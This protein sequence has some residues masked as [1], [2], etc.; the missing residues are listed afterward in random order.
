LASKN[1]FFAETG[2]GG[3]NPR[4]N[5]KALELWLA[6][7]KSE[8]DKQPLN[9]IKQMI[10]IAPNERVT[11]AGLM[12]Q[13]HNYEDSHVYYNSC[14]NGEEESE[15][16]TSYHGSTLEEDA[17][18]IKDS[19]NST[20]TRMDGGAA[21]TVAPTSNQDLNEVSIPHRA[22]PLGSLN[23]KN[24]IELEGI[25]QRSDAAS[26]RAITDAQATQLLLDNSFDIHAN[27]FNIKDALHWAAR[28]GHEAVVRLLVEKGADI[29]AKSDDRWTALNHAARGGHETVVRLL[30][31]K[32]ADID[33]KTMYGWTALNHAA[34]GGHEAV[35]RLLVEKGA[36]IN[37]KNMYGWA[38]LNHGAFG[39]HEA[40]VRLLVEKGADIDVMSDDGQTA[41][42]HAV[43]GGHEAV[44]RLLEEKGADINAKNKYGLTALDQAAFGGHETVVRLLVEKGADI[45]AKNKYGQTALDH[46][47]S[48][49][50]EAVVRLLVEKGA[51]K[52]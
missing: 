35:A 39:G 37:A 33:T 19:E 36:D 4:T 52:S 9:W 11:A 18:A 30:I 42:N 15:D 45:N 31:E 1:Q 43:S 27:I 16:G 23:G 7:L 2:T 12:E 44:V 3:A 34:F 14:C 8:T 6:R 50:H 40:V 25:F 5:T 26:E 10:K 47:A 32:G 20:E 24:Q 38:A 48:G 17:G 49:R 13:I 21:N 28:E 41:L 51:H 22:L 29:D 46:A